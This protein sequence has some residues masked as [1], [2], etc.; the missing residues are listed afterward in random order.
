MNALSK[1]IERLK[2]AVTAPMD[3]IV[4][5]MTR[6]HESFEDAWRREHGNRA[7]PEGQRLRVVLV[8]RSP[9]SGGALDG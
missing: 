3:R 5:V 9:V 7:I 4:A 8:G 1:R 2:E 6:E